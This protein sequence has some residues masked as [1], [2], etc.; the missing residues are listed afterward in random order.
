MKT[1]YVYIMADKPFGTLYI[2]ITSDLIRRVFE[3]KEQLVKGFTSEY[4]LHQLVY[5]EE[6]NEVS[7]AL[8]REKNLKHCLRDWKIKLIS[9]FNSQWDDLSLA[10]MDPR[11]KPEDGKIIAPEY[12]RI[13]V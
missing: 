11:V 12:D 2:G 9:D 4:D 1:Y 7:V 3:H 10:W 6:T 8:Q 5:F 13:A